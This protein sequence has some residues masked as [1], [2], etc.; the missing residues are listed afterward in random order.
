MTKH[1]N[2]EQINSAFLNKDKSE[3]NLILYN[4]NYNEFNFV[5]DS[6]INVCGHQKEQATQCTV[7]AHL[8]GK[9]NVKKGSYEDLKPMK[10]G[11]RKKGLTASIE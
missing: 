9:S 11:L 10:N 6:L 7:I 3:Q 1:S 8:K 2:K 5:I 4:D